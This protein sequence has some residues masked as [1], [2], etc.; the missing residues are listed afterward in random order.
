MAVTFFKRHELAIVLLI[1]IVAATVRCYR[2]SNPL[3][4][5]HAWRQAD[6]ASVTREYV[7]HGIKPLQPT[8]LDLS[9][10]PSG[11]DNPHGYR[12]VEFP[13]ISIIT[14]SILRSFPFLPL[15]QTSRVFSIVFS[16][17]GLAALY[18]LVRSI[19]GY[20]GALA[21]ALTYAFLPYSVYY[22][23]T[24]LPEPVL[25][26][27]ILVSLFAFQNWL[28]TKKI[29][30]Y[31]LAF[32]TLLCSYLLKPFALFFAPVFF[33]LAYVRYSWKMIFNPWLWLIAFIPPLPMLWWRSWITQ[34]PEGIPGSSW[35]FNGNGIRFKT[36]W[37]RWLFYERLNRLM[38][39]TLGTILIGANVL[40]V[41]IKELIIYGLWWFGM[42]AYLSIFAT[43]NVQHDYY[44]ALLIPIVS[45]SIGRGSIVLIRSL[46]RLRVSVGSFIAFCLWLIATMAYGSTL[47]FGWQLS[48]YFPEKIVKEFIVMLCSS[49]AVLSIVAWRLRYRRVPTWLAITIAAALFIG[50]VICSWQYVGGYFN[51]NQ[52]QFLRAGQAVQAIAPPDALIIAPNMG[53]TQFLFQTDRRGWPIGGEIDAK[54]HQ[55]ASYYVST[56]RD[57]E[58]NSLLSRFA[59]VTATPEFVIINLQLPLEASAA[60]ESAQ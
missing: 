32:V 23:R 13:I 37:V 15:E 30:W 22:S 16:I 11:A 5:W 33:A 42:L 14:A 38:S 51:V 3:L 36:S 7:K 34:Y 40:Q 59:V 53:D 41:S 57:D 8:Y 58:T 6:T 25:V 29:G 10:T 50:S 21:V 52:W 1:L 54:I 20:G 17:L 56:N 28:T 9:S 19:S 12:M 24:V 60:A 44:Q 47:V 26:G 4:D 18:G 27:L 45:I 49:V 46:T 39:G 2:L 48:G 43:G 35:L 55:G 31:T